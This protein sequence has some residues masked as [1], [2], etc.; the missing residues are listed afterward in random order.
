MN[1]VVLKVDPGRLWGWHA[2]LCQQLGALPGVS[3]EIAVDAPSGPA[4]P[5]P[6]AVRQVFALERLGGR[7]AHT[8]FAALDPRQLNA[9][10]TGDPGRPLPQL[11]IDL[12]ATTLP[13][14]MDRATPP[15]PRTLIPLYDG[16]PGEDAMWAALLD[17]RQ[18][19]LAVHDSAAGGMIDIGQCAIET[20]HALQRATASVV[21]RL[22][23]GLAHVITGRLTSVTTRTADRSDGL[24]AGVGAA[25]G[26]VGRKLCVKAR[27]VTDRVRGAEQWAVAWASREAGSGWPSEC[28]SGPGAGGQLHLDSRDYQ[29]LADDG[30][31]YYADPFLFEHNGEVHLFVEEL[32][33]ATNRGIISATILPSDGSLPATPRPVLE[34]AFHLSYPQVFARDGEIW[35]LPEQHQSGTLIL[36]RAQ[37]FPD[38]WE[39]AATL[40][41]EP[42]HDATLFDHGGRLWIAATHEGPVFVGPSF[43][44][45]RWG[46]SWD[47]L[48]LYHAPHLLGPWTRHTGNPVLIDAATARPAGPMFHAADGTLMRP[49]QDCSIGYGIALGLARIDRLDVTTYAQS[50]VS[51]I[52]FADG[53]GLTGPHTLSRLDGRAKSIEAIDVFGR[54][55]AL[56]K[57]FRR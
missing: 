9:V 18:P 44:G 40:I 4:R 11:I 23:E 43:G 53:H 26:I 54:R 17:G 32:P 19:Y 42:L 7:A 29:L 48:A 36:Y 33:Y 14:V 35:M 15:A 56:A 22:I 13:A 3:V 57:A 52:A 30:R 39:P 28:L 45:P 47:A 1:S 25:A 37:Q 21:V 41:D 6:S 51:C 38:A 46:S 34:T 10:P 5:L 8:A 50:I 31:R 20:P 2:A 55:N 12:V 49:V 16:K 24:S 27:R